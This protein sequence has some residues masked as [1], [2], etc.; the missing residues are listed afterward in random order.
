LVRPGCGREIAEIVAG[1]WT[2]DVARTRTTKKLAQRIDLNYFKRTTPLKR[3]RLWLSIAAPLLAVM[4]ISW[5]AF[6]RDPRVYSS[7]RMSA[8]HAILEKQCAACHVQKAS[9]F[10]AKAENQACLSCHDG[11]IHHANQVAAPDCA[12]C[13]S[14]HRGRV[15]ITAVSEKN[16][17]QCHANLRTVGTDSRYSNH[18]QSFADGHPE[19]AVLRENQRDPSTIKL[20]HAIHMKP[21]RRS[22]TGP[23]VQ[24]NCA[25]CHRAAVVKTS[26]TYADANYSG[27]S[28]A[29]QS[30]SDARTGGSLAPHSPST[31]RELMAPVT[32]ANACA[33]CHLLSFDKRFSEGVPHDK[34][35]VI[36]VF[37]KK[38]FREYATAHPSELRVMRD[39]D[40][41]LTGKPLAPIVQTLTAEQWVTART[42]DAEQLL[43]RKTCLQC[44]QLSFSRKTLPPQS[45]PIRNVQ[46]AD[47]ILPQIAGS[48]VLVRWMPHAKFDHEAHGSF[49]CTSCHEKALSSVASSD[50]LLP[51][52]KAC[53]TCHAPGPEHAESRCFECHTYHDWSRRKEI[54]P[55]FN[56]PPLQTGGR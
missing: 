31:G 9:F 55:T 6:H 40:R 15:R 19:F 33:S 49:T 46:Q 35:E 5:Y 24:L 47:E 50:V 21:I 45:A 42:L 7:G 48:N 41:D 25:D 28:S 43:W 37:L 2:T 16:C 3:A 8:P 29:A 20:N 30:Q 54:T 53:Q 32:F 38:K 10:S 18:I 12:T 52:I 56:F 23:I 26:W 39:P 14:E 4:W 22:P 44:H 17:A 27:S 51:G 11:P 13:H 1:A 34:P 36:D